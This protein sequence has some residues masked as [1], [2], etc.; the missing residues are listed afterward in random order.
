MR[1]YL[2][3]VLFCFSLMISGIEHF[4]IYLLAIIWKN[5][6]SDL[7]TILEIE[8]FILFAIGLYEFSIDFGY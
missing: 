7:L 8:L 2:I 5:V 4:Y 1:Q 6:H 3:M